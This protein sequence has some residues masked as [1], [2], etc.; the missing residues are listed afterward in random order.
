MYTYRHR[1]TYIWVYSSFA[2]S[3]G[4]GNFGTE[5]ILSSHSPLFVRAIPVGSCLSRRSAAVKY[6]KK[7][8][9]AR[10]DAARHLQARLRAVMAFNA[11]TMMV[12]SVCSSKRLW[13]CD[14][15]AFYNHTCFF[16]V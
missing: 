6:C 5:H 7:L 4:V 15:K 11:H 14:D 10:E 16:S 9:H 3:H 2:T 13:I 12:V 1:R 8:E